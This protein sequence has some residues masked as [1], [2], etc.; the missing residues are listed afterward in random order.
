MK[1]GKAAVLGVVLLQTI[2]CLLLWGKSTRLQS[3]LD[4]Q[5][6]DS[7]IREQVISQ[8]MECIIDD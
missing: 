4:T 8:L 2:G 6:K 7:R 3:A 5:S 1:W